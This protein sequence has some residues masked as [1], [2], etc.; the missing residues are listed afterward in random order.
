MHSDF[1]NTLYKH[2]QYNSNCLY[3]LK[4]L[5]LVLSSNMARNLK[6]VQAFIYFISTKLVPADAADSYEQARYF[7]QLLA[8]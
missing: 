2:M 4:E 8:Q 5:A 7:W 1:P 6:E 3:F